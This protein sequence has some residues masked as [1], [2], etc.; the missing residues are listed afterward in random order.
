MIVTL[1][2]AQAMM[3]TGEGCGCGPGNHPFSQTQLCFYPNDAFGLWQ[4]LEAQRLEK[5]GDNHRPP[6]TVHR[7]S[8]GCEPVNQP[9]GC[10]ALRARISVVEDPPDPLPQLYGR[11][12]NGAIENPRA[13]KQHWIP[14]QTKSIFE[15]GVNEHIGKDLCN[16]FSGQLNQR[17]VN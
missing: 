4:A 2:R 12:L 17:L 15:Q 11:L 10:G 5:I 6:F 8:G 1:K 9:C 3:L 16:H 7:F 13:D 14:S